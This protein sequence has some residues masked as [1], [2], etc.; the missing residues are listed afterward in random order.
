[1][2]NQSRQ[3]LFICRG[4]MMKVYTYV[5]IDIS[6]GETLEERSFEYTGDVALCKGGGGQSSVDKAY[7][8]RLASIYEQ[9]L[10]MAQEYFAFWQSDYKPFEQAQIKENMKM[11][12][13]LTQAEIGKS[14]AEVEGSK[15]QVAQFQGMLA[16]DAQGQSLLGLQQDEHRASLQQSLELKPQQTQ[17]AKKAYESALSGV[18]E[19][20]AAKRAQAGVSMA[21]NESER[22]LR[23]ELG[24][25]GVGTSGDQYTAAMAGLTR[26]RA[27]ATAGAMTQGRTDAQREEFE[28]LYGLMNTQKK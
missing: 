5:R 22:D 12:P 23:R 20:A 17:I 27:K 10:S 2:G 25:V 11:L 1:M 26:D 18:D 19:D 6:T 14:Q 21:F 24:R 7:N 15:F 3:R 9:E 8:A 13:Y 4:K 16:K 28:R